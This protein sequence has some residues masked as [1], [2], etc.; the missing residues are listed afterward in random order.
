[1]CGVIKFFSFSNLK[2]LK[3][4]FENKFSIFVIRKF[5]KVVRSFEAMMMGG[6]PGQV[7]CIF[8]L[9][10][11]MLEASCI[12]KGSL[13]LQRSSPFPMRGKEGPHGEA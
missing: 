11:V 10:F 13:L 6:C 2:F 9:N 5:Q 1:M 12:E 3:T 7:Y 8:R 4:S